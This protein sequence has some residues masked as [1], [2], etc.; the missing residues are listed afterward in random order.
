MQGIS[1]HLEQRHGHRRLAQSGGGDGEEHGGGEQADRTGGVGLELGE[2]LAVA[3]GGGDDGENA[4]R[5]EEA[6][7]DYQMI[8]PSLSRF[9]HR[10]SRTHAAIRV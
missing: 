1:E 2:V 8:F 10:C 7:R 5:E 6:L 9:Y 4:R 3:T